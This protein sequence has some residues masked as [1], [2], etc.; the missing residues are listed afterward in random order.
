MSTYAKERETHIEENVYHHS[1]IKII[2]I[3]VL[4]K[5][6]KRWEKFLLENYFVDDEEPSSPETKEV[7]LMDKMRKKAWTH[8]YLKEEVRKDKEV[9]VT[10]E[11]VG[12]N[13]NLKGTYT[14]AKRFTRS[15]DAKLGIEENA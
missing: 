13:P 10:R 7:E 12:K 1:L 3:E 5:Q 2:V 8:G 9:V 15:Q 6:N 11:T 14:L 4:R